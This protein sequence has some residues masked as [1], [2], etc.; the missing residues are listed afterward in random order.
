[1]MPWEMNFQ[2]T[3]PPVN[4]NQQIKEIF[5]PDD[6]A[7]PKPWELDYTQSNDASGA[8]GKSFGENIFAPKNGWDNYGQPFVDTFKQGASDLGDFATG[9]YPNPGKG[10]MAH[11]L[12]DKIKGG[13]A[14]RHDYERAFM[15]GFSDNPAGK[16]LGAVSGIVPEFNAVT[17]SLNKWIN[18][19]IADKTGIDPTEL[20][21]A[22]MALP[23]AARS[24]AVSDT[25]L[26]SA[27]A[28]KAITYPVRHPLDTT[29]MAINLATKPALLAA[30]PIARGII[31]GDNPIT[32]EPGLKTALQSDIATEGTRLGDKLGVQFSA[33]ELTGNPTALGIEDALAN[34]A[35]WGGKFAEANRA[36]TDAIT[37]RFT[38]LLDKIYPESG[39]RADVGDRVSAAYNNTLNSLVKT[40]GEQAKVDFQAALK[41]DEGNANILANN[42][43]KELQAIK[44]EGDAKLLTKSKAHGAAVARAILNRTSSKTKSGNIQADTISLQDMANGLSDFSAESRRSGGVLDNAQSAAERRVYARLFGALQKDLDAEIAKPKGNPQRAAML[45]VARDNFRNHSNQIADIEKTAIGKLVGGA[46]HNSQGQ[47]MV[48]PEKMADTISAMQPTE[49]R[50]TLSF[51][52]KNHPDVAM[53][54]R[55][56][57]LERAF[58]SAQEGRGL[59]G[60]GTTKEFSK[61]EFVKALPDKE[62]LNALL[63][64]PA[65]YKDVTDIA[66]AMNRLIDYGAQKKGSQTAQRTDFLHSIASWGKGAFYRSLV[67]DSLAEDLLNPTKRR[68]IAME[69]RQKGKK[70]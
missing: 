49:L 8:L 41:G 38:T 14:D 54:A 65:A 3:P 35:R 63:K 50:N 58:R 69:A 32:G 12:A 46:E 44:S 2:K 26:P 6:Q 16:M 17:T 39:S 27:A 13:T 68:Q 21:M 33:G 20:Q 57:V 19:A 31:E 55:R 47:L 11:A 52:D 51:L 45:A 24:R 42:L 9:E 1:M 37:N 48:S 30:R 5:T 29:G 53:M 64:D 59:R 34:S 62:K 7:A 61:A 18:P 10:P 66:S 56:H 60:E 40:R 25:Q 67:S 22:E 36:K 70:P 23:L 28:V 43:F 15:E 4:A